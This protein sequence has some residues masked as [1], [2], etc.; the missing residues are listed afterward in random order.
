VRIAVNAHGAERVPVRLAFIPIGTQEESVHVTV[1]EDVTL[2]LPDGHWRVEAASPGLWHAPQFFTAGAGRELAIDLWAAANVTGTLADRAGAPSEMRVRFE[3][4]EVACPVEQGRFTCV[5]PAGTQTLHVRA[6]GFVST[7]I[8]DVRAAAGAT[9]DLGVLR[10]RPGQSII[11]RVELPARR[12]LSMEDV[13][14]SASFGAAVKRET[15]PGPRGWFVLDGLTPGTYEVRARATKLISESRPIR[16]TAGRESE[17]S[18][19]LRLDE[20]RTIALRIFP[21]LDPDGKPWHVR[22]QQQLTPQRLALVE[23]RSA[24]PGGAWTSP[25][26]MP[27]TYEVVIGTTGGDVWH[28]R[29]VELQRDELLHVGLLARELSGTIRIGDAPLQA[30]LTLTDGVSSELR[31]SSDAEGRFRVTVPGGAVTAWDVTIVADD[32]KVKR[33]LEHVAVSP[34]GTLDIRL[35][36]TILVGEARYAGGAPAANALVTLTRRESDEHI[37]VQTSSGPDGTFILHALP[38]GRYEIDA[39]SSDGASDTVTVD[40]PADEIVVVLHPKR[41]VRGQVLSQFG[42]VAG[43]EVVVYSTHPLATR[44]VPVTTN[45][46]GLFEVSVAPSA[47]TLN[48]LVAASGFAYTLDH[49]PYRDE[50][51]IVSLEH[52][53]GTLRIR[54]TRDPASLYIVQEGAAVA[55]DMV[56]LSWSPRA[57][58]GEIVLPMMEPGPYA[59][60]AVAREQRARFVQ[61]GGAGG[62]TCASAFLPMHG[63]AVLNV[64]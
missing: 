34:S 4:G 11:G 3:A 64:E 60:C 22:L 21:S 26:L 48:V 24:T 62:G 55:F 53:G 28:R 18:E 27:A 54:T 56:A 19:S 50:P 20:P 61:S 32:P 23:E 31:T 49:V 13:T 38:A 58:A 35:P 46:R 14:V 51:L 17:L 7:I 10:L 9:H 57:G 41:R 40:H 29:E 1:E 33:A 43:A 45:E 8:D 52:R 30:R 5:I 47:A 36:G 15:K 6:R 42:P 25:P 39:S 12:G 63:E 2:E 16:V 59:V 37:F 44:M